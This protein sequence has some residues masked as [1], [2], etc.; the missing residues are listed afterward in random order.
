LPF[1]AIAEWAADADQDT[2]RAL[3]AARAVPS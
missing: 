2:L 3:A 1:T